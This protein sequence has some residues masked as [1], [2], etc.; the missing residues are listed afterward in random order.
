MKK[1]ECEFN[2]TSTHLLDLDGYI[3]ANKKKITF[4]SKIT[5]YNRVVV[6]NTNL[7]FLKFE[8]DEWTDICNHGSK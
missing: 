8:R 4:L 1:K 7:Y 3:S 6:K 2:G 5:T